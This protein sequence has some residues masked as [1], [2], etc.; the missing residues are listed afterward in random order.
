MSKVMRTTMPKGY[1]DKAIKGLLTFL[2]GCN[3]CVL[4]EVKKGKNVQQAM[5]EELDEIKRRLEED[6]VATTVIFP[7]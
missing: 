2:Q 4:E 6:K 5:T 1:N 3:E 7:S